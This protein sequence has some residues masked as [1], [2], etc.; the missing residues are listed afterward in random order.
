MTT[1]KRAAADEGRERI[2]EAATLSFAE[3]GYAGTS[4]AAVAR[5]IGVTQPLVHHHFGSKE[6]LWRAAIDRLFVELPALVQL[7]A[8]A[9]SPRQRLARA[10]EGFIRLSAE[11]P[12]LGRILA[13]EGAAPGP[14]LDYLLERYVRAPFREAVATVR[15]AQQE[16]LVA[17]S[18][19]PE[20]LLFFV[21]G[22]GNYLFDVPALAKEIFDIDVAS[23]ETRDEFVALARHV[24]SVGVRREADEE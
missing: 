24:L 2:L 21:L 13:R 10:V 7:L 18:V 12:L 11:R 14:R 20:L 1:H 6:G 22:A 17:A 9:T 15:A 4:T 5:S 8:E 16:G 3:V 19:R 23:D